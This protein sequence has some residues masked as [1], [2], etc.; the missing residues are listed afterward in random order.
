MVGSREAWPGSWAQVTILQ[1]RSASERE[2]EEPFKPLIH[3]SPEAGVEITSL[4]CE[5]YK[6][7]HNSFKKVNTEETVS[8]GKK[9][10]NPENPLPFEQH[11]LLFFSRLKLQK[12]CSSKSDRPSSAN[13]ARPPEPTRAGGPSE[14]TRS[15]S[16]P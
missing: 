6:V 7:N 11:F 13:P 3:T 12:L 16:V 5:T 14:G 15:Q 10:K 9:K 4:T 8:F 1:Q 2:F